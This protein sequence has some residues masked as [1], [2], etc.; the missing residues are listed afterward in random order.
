M[1]MESIS[2]MADLDRRFR[3][4][5]GLSDRCD[6]RM[7]HPR[8]QPARIMVL[9]IK[10]AARRMTLTNWRAMASTSSGNVNMST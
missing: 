4:A 10:P 2:W 9:D 5:S 1:A 7:F 6:Y 8:L 3:N